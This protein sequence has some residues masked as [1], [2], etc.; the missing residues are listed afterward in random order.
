MLN[1][2]IWLKMCVHPDFMR[3]CKSA[4]PLGFV[5]IL[6]PNSL[7]TCSEEHVSCTRQGQTPV[8]LWQMLFDKEKKNTQPNQNKHITLPRH[9]HA[10]VWKSHKG[11]QETAKDTAQK[12]V[13]AERQLWAKT[14]QRLVS[15]YVT[16]VQDCAQRGLLKTQLGHRVHTEQARRDFFYF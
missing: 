1:A 9:R 6:C 12:W 7:Q 2:H 10:A 3:M 4:A 14:T 8:C 11:L 16:C 13:T 5:F 15:S